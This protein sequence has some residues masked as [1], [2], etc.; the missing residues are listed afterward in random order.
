[1]NE[2]AK[3]RFG[4]IV[5]W[6]EKEYSAIRTGQ[7]SPALLDGIK[8]DVYNSYMPISQVSSVNIEDPRTLRVTPWDMTQIVVIE[9]A[10]NDA[11]LGVSVVTDSNGLRVIFPELTSERRE[12]LR[13]LAKSKLEDARVSVRSVRDEMMKNTEKKQKESEIS[14]DDMHRQK[15]KI[16][17]AVNETNKE[18]EERYKKKEI[19]L[20]K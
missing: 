13:K 9:K 18:L 11:G 20:T 6:L 5:T 8:V 14:K 15:E 19:E 10:I 1:M 16:Q 17:I 12:Q 4:E 7:S 3:S 2:E